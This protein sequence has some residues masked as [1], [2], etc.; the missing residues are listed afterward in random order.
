MPGRS[1]PDRPGVSCVG[2]G[3]GVDVA[4]RVQS[5]ALPACAAVGGCHDGLITCRP[6]VLSVGEGHGVEL[7]LRARVL[8]PPGG[9]TV[10]VAR[11]G[12]SVL[13]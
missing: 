3:H 13:P 9:T 1:R 8:L 11:M 2:T 5:L 4:S 7:G 12:A 10:V 6:A